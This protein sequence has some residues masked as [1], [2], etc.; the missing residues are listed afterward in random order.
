MMNYEMFKEIVSEKLAEY[1]PDEYKDRQLEF[2]TF[3]K[4]NVKRD[5]VTFMVKEGDPR[6]SPTMYLDGL[7][8]DYKK[9]GDIEIILQNAA[10][11][12]CKHL[13]KGQNYMEKINLDAVGDNVFFFLINAEQ[14]REY[15]Q[16]RPHR[17]YND[18]AIVYDHLIEIG[19]DGILSVPITN[20]FARLAGYEEHELFE[21]SK[22]NTKRLFPTKI[23]PM[24]NI[25]AELMD[26]ETVPFELKEAIEQ[27]LKVNEPM[28]VI[29]NE[30]KHKGAGAMLYE[31]GLHE[32]STFLK[33][34]LYLL[35]SSIHELI[36]VSA[37]TM[38]PLELADMV[39]EINQMEV[40]IGDRLSNQVYHYDRTT[41]K[42]TMAT[43]TPNKSLSNYRE[44]Q[45][46]EV[47]RG[48]VR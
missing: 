10:I 42:V 48:T 22:E 47:T 23:Q 19:E 46:Y 5:G 8:E 30:W 16:N 7:Y 26:M 44:Q 12:L 39:Q 17:N 2:G 25:I 37:D 13:E 31:E 9:I 21:R 32:L 35:P 6:V 4:I 27:E 45:E 14:N 1:L 34:D 20:D 38:T 43:D 40:E 41:R 33:N 29:T 3:D 24:S 15:L 28:F 18:L 11:G 36:A